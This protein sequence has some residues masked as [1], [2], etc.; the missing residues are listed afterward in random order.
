MG[1]RY[2]PD[3]INPGYTRGVHTNFT[4]R[5]ALVEIGTARSGGGG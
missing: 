5:G 1:E 4:H 3:V 2:L